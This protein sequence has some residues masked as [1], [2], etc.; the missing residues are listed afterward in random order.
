MSTMAKGTP[1]PTNRDLVMVVLGLP[2]MLDLNNVN[3]HSIM[4]YLYILLPDL[5]EDIEAHN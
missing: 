2:N 5:A 3:V 4:K 1:Y